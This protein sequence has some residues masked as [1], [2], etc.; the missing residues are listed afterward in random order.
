MLHV[1]EAG[2]YSSTVFVL[3]ADRMKPWPV[4]PPMT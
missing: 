2:S 1:L 3:V 4:R